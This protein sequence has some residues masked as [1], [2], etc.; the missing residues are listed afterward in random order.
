MSETKREKR[1]RA[2]T[3]LTALLFAALF[4]ICVLFASGCQGYYY[5]VPSDRELVP[6]K[7]T[8]AAGEQITENGACSAE[9]ANLP[10]LQNDPA[11]RRTYVE[12]EGEDCT[13]WYVPNA[14]LTEW[15]EDLE[16]L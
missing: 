3:W 13:G 10:R 7:A 8:V 9:G 14:V 1:D 15:V 4:G 5:V 12:T 2:S 11:M 16:A 6:V